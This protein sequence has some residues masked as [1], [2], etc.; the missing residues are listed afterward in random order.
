M[1]ERVEQLDRAYAALADSTRRE[2]LHRLQ[3]G[4][5]RVTDVASTL[6]MSLAAVSKHIR[7]LER[8]GLV[9]R[10]VQGRE[11][12]L[13]VDRAALD[14]ARSWIEH[15]QQF[16]EVRADALVA[17]VTARGARAGRGKR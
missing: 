13:S 4:P 6:P 2:I 3:S 15:F 1:V 7:V 10:D 17:H 12:V 9:Q 8:A 16:W 11:H 14:G 5:A